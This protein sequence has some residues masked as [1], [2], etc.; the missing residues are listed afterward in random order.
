MTKNKGYRWFQAR[1]EAVFDDSG[2]A[3]RMA[4]SAQDIHDRKTAEEK[5]DQYREQLRSLASKAA[6]VGEHERRRIG[7]EL[8]DR[9][10]QNLGLM[11]V[12]LAEL[13]ASVD[14][15][16]GGVLFEETFSLVKET[17]RDT[18]ALWSELSPPVLYEL[19]FETG[20]DWLAE[21]VRVQH[22]LDCAVTDDGQSKPLSEDSQVILF[23]AVRELLANVA[24][25][26]EARK[27][28][29]DLRHCDGEICIIVEDD[30]K[31][32]DVGE[33]PFE[34]T[35]EGGFGLFSIRERMTFLGGRL[36][37][38]SESGKGTTAI[39]R[40]PLKVLPRPEA[41]RVA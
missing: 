38:R 3:V 21:R 17:I 40:A 10:I 8:H 11:R 1:G 31:G 28:S 18:R 15:A 37:L 41:E 32:F 36:E 12:R 6:L 27:V 24:K 2:V 5:L 4:G 29:V 19:G 33:A 23:Q 25:H 16:S 20:V 34:M 39:L 35:E 7:I 14:V 26:A 9:T 30:G 13:R 22:D